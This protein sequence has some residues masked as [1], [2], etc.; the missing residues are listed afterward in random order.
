M[1]TKSTGPDADDADTYFWSLVKDP[2]KVSRFKVQMEFT[3]HLDGEEYWRHAWTKAKSPDRVSPETLARHRAT[4]IAFCY[5]ETATKNKTDVVPSKYN[6]YLAGRSRR[7]NKNQNGGGCLVWAVDTVKTAT[8]VTYRLNVGDDAL[9]SEGDGTSERETATKNGKKS[10]RSNE[11]KNK[12]KSR[13]TK[14]RGQGSQG[15]CAAS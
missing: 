9:S 6:T 15:T 1:S 12:S 13:N 2:S 11:S 8:G 4:A 5:A 14:D 3:K 10:K 7:H